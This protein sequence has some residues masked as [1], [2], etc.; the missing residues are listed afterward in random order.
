MSILKRPLLT[1][2]STR[3]S[4]K[5]RQYGFEVQINAEK[6]DIKT[7]VESL[8]N[9]QVERVNTL[10]VRGKRRTRM[11]KRGILSGKNSNYKKAIVTLKPGFDIDFFK[12][13]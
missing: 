12:H 10:I 2:K 9:V 3:T 6:G 1:E 4:E 8:Y 5:L 7:A 13:I 11:T